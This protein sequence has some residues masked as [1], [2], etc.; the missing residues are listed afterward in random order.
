[1]LTNVWVNY[2]DLNNQRVGVLPLALSRAPRVISE[3]K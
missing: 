2:D 3:C 1:M